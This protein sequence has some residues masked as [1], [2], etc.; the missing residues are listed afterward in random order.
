MSADYRRMVA[1]LNRALD[2]RNPKVTGEDIATKLKRHGNTVRG[3]LNCEHKID[4]DDLAEIARIYQLSLDDL[5]NRQEGEE[6]IG[7]IDIPPAPD[8]E[9]AT[10]IG[11]R[12]LAIIERWHAREQEKR[13]RQS[14]LDAGTDNGADREAT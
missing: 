6:T 5:W 2:D 11:R 3:W 4:A 10:D 12:L 8:D 14:E 13:R 9:Q 1:R 7:F